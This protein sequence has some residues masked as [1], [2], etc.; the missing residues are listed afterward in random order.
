MATP[1]RTPGQAPQQAPEPEHLLI[2]EEVDSSKWSVPPWGVMGVGL[3]IIFIVIGIVSYV[4][5]PKPKATGSIDEVFAVAMAENQVMTTVKIN[6]HNIGGK[7]LWI[8][9]VT[10]KV[11]TDQGEFTDTFANAVDYPR[12]FAAYPDLRE[13]TMTPVKAEDRIRPGEMERGSVIFSF[14]VSYDQFNNRKSL[15]VIIDPYDQPPV[16]LTK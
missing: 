9:S 14:P 10:G 2:P 15:S 6:I 1:E 3:L 11:V 16:I 13:H 7:P 8:R 5:R 4:M 12:Y